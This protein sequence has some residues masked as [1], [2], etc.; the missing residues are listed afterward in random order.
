MLSSLP[1]L[2]PKVLAALPL[3]LLQKVTEAVH[4]YVEKQ[5]LQVPSQSETLDEGPGASHYKQ[6][7]SK[8]GVDLIARSPEGGWLTHDELGEYNFR[9]TRAL[10]KEQWL[11]GFIAAVQIMFALKP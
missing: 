10:K 8:T 11:D 2:D 4:A 1:P 7:A 3:E 9:L 6:V 5:A